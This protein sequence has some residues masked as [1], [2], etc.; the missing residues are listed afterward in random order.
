M[1]TIGKL[2]FPACNF[3]CFFLNSLFLI[4]ANKPLTLLNE[5]LMWS[6]YPLSIQ[7]R[8]K[9]GLASKTQNN[10]D[11]SNKPNGQT[12]LCLVALLLKILL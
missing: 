1:N 4:C 8:A 9:V 5:D 10:R 11:P 2:Q 3:E 6:F 12:T 7:L